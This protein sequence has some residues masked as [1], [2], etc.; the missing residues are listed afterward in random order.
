MAKNN[1]YSPDGG[2]HG[3]EGGPTWDGDQKANT[4]KSKAAGIRWERK[5]SKR[6]KKKA[7]D[8]D[9]PIDPDKDDPND[10]PEGNLRS[11]D[12]LLELFR[13]DI[14]ALRMHPFDDWGYRIARPLTSADGAKPGV[15][16]PDNKTRKVGRPRLRDSVTILRDLAL[17]EPAIDDGAAALVRLPLGDTSINPADITHEMEK[18]H[19]YVRTLH[20]AAQIL[21]TYDY[22]EQKVVRRKIKKEK[23]RKSRSKKTAKE[24]EDIETFDGAPGK[25]VEEIDQYE[26]VP[27]IVLTE[28]WR[29]AKGVTSN[30]H[31]KTV[32]VSPG[33]SRSIQLLI[34]AGRVLEVRK[35]LDD[36]I[37]PLSE[38]FEAIFPVS[39]VVCAGWHVR[40]GQLHLDL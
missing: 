25:K 22:P 14:S 29:L 35:I 27:K 8:P 1:A 12:S 15:L 19:P 17:G 6:P 37:I 16:L 26:D 3:L 18:A 38:R 24:D 30:L 2:G 7:S 23:L 4:G 28:R 31:R 39:E 33:L 34:E 9:G 13:S 40:S 36:L 10:R 20:L 5:D 11:D 32:D 21:A